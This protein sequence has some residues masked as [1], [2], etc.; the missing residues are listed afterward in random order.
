MHWLPIPGA[1]IDP[2]QLETIDQLM[3]SGE[4]GGSRT[5]GLEEDMGFG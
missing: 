1:S 5:A 4:K 3:K 2:Q